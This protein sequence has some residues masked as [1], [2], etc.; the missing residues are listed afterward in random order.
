MASRNLADL[1]GPVQS[2]ARAMLAAADLQGFGLLVYCTLRS[3]AEQADL[4]ASGRTRTGPILTNAKPGQSLHN[5]GADGKAWAFDCV[6]MRGG[7]AQWGDAAALQKMG[8]LG[9]RYGLEWA[10]RW[11][12]ALRE[13]VHFQID[14]KRGS[15]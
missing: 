13:S 5:P 12:G 2:A 3:H 9:E 14:K 10:G 1:A 4:Y 8:E 15:A 11:R 7:I 6:P